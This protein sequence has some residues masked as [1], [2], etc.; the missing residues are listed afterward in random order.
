MTDAETL[1]S[2]R[3]EQLREILEREQ[4]RPVSHEE[5]LSVGESLVVF[6]EILAQDSGE[7]AEI[8]T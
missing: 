1:G 2:E 6:Y 7:T 4:A 3:I 5:A 8:G